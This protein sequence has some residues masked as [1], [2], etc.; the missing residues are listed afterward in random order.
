MK[1][2]NPKMSIAPWARTL[3]ILPAFI[4]I[5]GLFEQISN[6]VLGIDSSNIHFQGSLFQETVGVLFTLIGTIVVVGIFR[7]FMDM[8]SFRSMGFY[9]K[10]IGREFV[11]GLG[12]GAIIMAT[13]F[14]T[15]VFIHEIEWTVTN[16]ETV[17]ILQSVSLFA[18]VSLSEEL[19]LRGYVLN[20][21]MKTMNR[22]RA[23]ILSSLM[24]TLLHVFNPNLSWIG[25]F[26]ILLAGILLGLP[27]IYTQRLW[28]PLALHFS[29]NFF[30]GP[31][32]GFHVSGHETYSLITQ[33]RTTDNIWNGG[34]FGF[35]GSVLSL[36]YEAMAIFILWRYFNSKALTISDDIIL[37]MNYEADVLVK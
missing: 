1:L 4:V 24:F 6:L 29:W 15:L 35:E 32:F 37:P 31:I 13:G 17:S 19:L 12:L 18:M 36:V 33:S 30:Q 14:T 28:L 21:L 23:L 27:Y 26:N 3:L 34:T 5:V 8:E 25:F 22:F 2:T 10:G 11:F 9:P 16:F 20:N 7:R